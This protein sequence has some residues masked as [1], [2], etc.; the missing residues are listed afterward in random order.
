MCGVAFGISLNSFESLTLKEGIYSRGKDNFGSFN[1]SEGHELYHSRLSILD[2]SA[3]GNQPMLS[4]NKKWVISFNGEIYNYIE[5]KKKYNIKTKT[6]TDTEVL[7]ELISK[8]GINAIKELKGPFALIL[9]DTLTNKKYFCRDAFGEKPLYV[10]KLLDKLAISSTLKSLTWKNS[11]LNKEYILDFLSSDFSLSNS[12]ILKN[13]NSVEPGILFEIENTDIKKVLDFTIHKFPPSKKNHRDLSLIKKQVTKSILSKVNSDVP[14]CLFLSG[15]LDSSII[16]QVISESKLNKL[17][18]AFSIGFDSKL[19]ESKLAKKWS[20]EI[21]INH[22]TIL[23]TPKEILDLLPEFIQDMDNPT[24]DGLNVWLISKYTSSKGYTVALSGLGGDEIFA[25]YKVFYR[26]YFMKIFQPLLQL[27]RFFLSCFSFYKFRS[28]LFYNDVNLNFNNWAYKF[29]R[30]TVNANYVKS[31]IINYKRNPENNFLKNNQQG[32]INLWTLNE[33]SQYTSKVLMNDSDTF[34]MSNDQEIRMPFVDLDLLSLIMCYP[35]YKKLSFKYNK[36]L[37]YK[38]FENL[39]PEYIVKK[40]KTGFSLPWK[41]WLRGELKNEVISQIKDLKL[42][43][44]FKEDFI[45]KELLWFN[46][47][48]DANWAFIWKLFILEKWLKLN[49]DKK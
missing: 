38:S 26:F 29:L 46:K 7:I 8:Q 25:G 9:I 6:S 18:K 23:I 47:K 33:F 11:K 45:D 41:K 24:V 48:N 17:I 15:G 31:N 35:D 5:L 12:T 3:N 2:L 1:T 40:Q 4:K 36:P 21:N 22:E 30:S 10:Y 28:K 32:S 20:D 16:A 37:L 49:Y 34:G 27:F 19:D 43:G 14:V 44:I 13:I 42:R 39:L